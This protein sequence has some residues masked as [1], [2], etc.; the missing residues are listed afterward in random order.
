MSCQGQG[1]SGGLFCPFKHS[2]QAIKGI[3]HS[4]NFVTAWPGWLAG[5]DRLAM[6]CQPGSSPRCSRVSLP[7]PV[8]SSQPRRTCNRH[9]ERQAVLDTCC[10]PWLSLRK[11]RLP[12]PRCCCS[13]WP[14]YAAALSQGQQGRPAYRGPNAERLRA[15]Q[16]A[17]RQKSSSLGSPFCCRPRSLQQG[18]GSSGGSGGGSSPG[19]SPPPSPSSKQPSPPPPKLLGATCNTT[20][21]VNWEG[22]WAA[23]RRAHS[24]SGPG[25]PTGAARL[26]SI[27]V[28]VWLWRA[29]WQSLPPYVQ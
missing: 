15:G 26:L 8:R 17:S 1:C 20:G 4:E 12:G 11:L 29:R 18:G 3:I 6:R 19:P 13:C 28:A 5:Q 24:T 10:S 21:P 2:Q 27:L 25:N 9:S 22:G 23:R 16:D 14:P 7:L